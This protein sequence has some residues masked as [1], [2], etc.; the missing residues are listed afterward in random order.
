M[1]IRSRYCAR[2]CRSST[3]PVSCSIRSASVDLPWSMWAMMQKFRIR[4]GSVKVVSA[5]VGMELLLER[6]LR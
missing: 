5:K 3:T 6:E 1:S 4:A 2:I